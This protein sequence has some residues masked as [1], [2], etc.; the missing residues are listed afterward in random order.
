MLRESSTWILVKCYNAGNFNTKLNFKWTRRNIT[1]IQAEIATNNE[2]KV[3][4]FKLNLT[5]VIQRI[6]NTKVNLEQKLKTWI[7]NSN[8]GETTISTALVNNFINLLG[9][10]GFVKNK[11]NVTFKGINVTNTE[12]VRRTT[13]L[14]FHINL[15]DYSVENVANRNSRVRKQLSVPKVVTI[16]LPKD[17]YTE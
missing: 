11:T 1:W 4:K 5:T 16:Q 6:R 2:K 7:N 8:V 10:N 17:I 9:A 14:R 3:I 15:R 13:I 12:L